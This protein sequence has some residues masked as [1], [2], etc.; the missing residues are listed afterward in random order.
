MTHYGELN[1][2]TGWIFISLGITTGSIIG[3]W[4]FDGPFPTPKGHTNYTDLPRRLNRLAHIACFMLPLISI[5]YGQYLDQALLTDAQKLIGAYSMVTC[6]IGVP[7]FLFLA[8]FYLP[9]KYLEVI[10]VTAGCV[11][12]YLMSW[13]HLKILCSFN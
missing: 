4:S 8:S 6:M 9:F 11:A 7:L 10:P 12:L 3:L 5:V 2:T 1:I 13:A